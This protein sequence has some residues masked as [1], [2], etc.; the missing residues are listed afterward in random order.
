M[1]DDIIDLL[2]NNFET[3]KSLKEIALD[4]QH[5]EWLIVKSGLRIV[6][7]HADWQR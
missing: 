6:R 5:L 7:I 3:D 2:I 4:Y 1:Y